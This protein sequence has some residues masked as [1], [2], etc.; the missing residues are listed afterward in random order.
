[1]SKQATKIRGKSRKIDSVKNISEK[2]TRTKAIFF[3][4]YRGL[5]H[6][7][8]ETLRKSLK[9]VTAEYEIAKNTLIKI[10]VKE[11]NKDISTDI[12]SY[13]KN[14][15]AA[16]FAFGDGIEA[17]KTLSAF[18]KTNALP[19]IKIGF[20]EG[21]IIRDTDFTKLASL[22]A[23]PVLLATL[24][25]RMQAPVYGLHYGLTWNL[26]KLATVL[27]NVKEKKPAN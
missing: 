23:K 6:Q 5:T 15:T 19:K 2:L 4:D 24:L 13:L 25:M 21:K 7:Q 11:W 1:M 14:P 18:I 26:R 22:P 12:E 3:T 27:N 10:A 17:V 16:L 20:F 8:L 9:K